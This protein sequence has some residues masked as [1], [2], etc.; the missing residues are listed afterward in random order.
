MTGPLL[1]GAPDPR[2]DIHRSMPFSDEAEKGLLSCMLQNPDLIDEAAESQMLQS[3]YHPANALLLQKL[4][5]YRNKG[6]P[7]ELPAISVPLLGE[8]LM[9]KI[10]GPATLAELYNFVP[11]PAH[12]P[13]YQS[14]LSDNYLLRR[15]I[16]TATEA[17]QGA[18]EHR[19]DVLAFLDECEQRALALRP[20]ESV[21]GDLIAHCVLD[22]YDEIEAQTRSGGGL[23]GKPTGFRWLDTMTRGIRPEIWFIGARP[24]VGKT[25]IL[26][27]IIEGY[28]Q[29]GEPVGMFSLEMS[30]LMIVKRLISIMS[31][32]QFDRIMAGTLNPAEIREIARATDK[33]QKAKF[34]CDD[35]SAL[36]HSQVRAKARRWKRQFDVQMIGLDYLQRMAATDGKKNR[37]R[38]DEH[39]ENCTALADGVKEL[40]I[41]WIVLAQL[42]REC[43]KGNR[44]PKLSDFEGCGRI[45]QDADVALMLSKTGDETADGERVV[46][47]D[48]AKQRNN[49]TGEKLHLFRTKFAAFGAFP[50]EPKEEDEPRRKDIHG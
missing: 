14:I 38:T 20:K 19:E 50:F 8:K 42:N 29:R 10:G 5:E 25:S 23:T 21:Q 9:D 32:V 18:Y 41:P 33:I 15:I 24:S 31:K 40:G 43:E 48:V 27:Q 36:T 39:A 7:I 16:E 47:F 3:F 45:E 13:Y 6:I 28:I 46:N 12:W 49:P 44:K 4:I 34:Y 17:I 30:R 37:N 26:L 35:R 22:V 2:Q 1:N 11:T